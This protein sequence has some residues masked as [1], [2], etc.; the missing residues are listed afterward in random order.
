MNAPYLEPAT[1]NRVALVT[2]AGSGSGRAIAIALAEDGCDV[3]IL[4]RR[5]E[6]LEETATAIRARGRR[7]CIL[8]T[9][10]CDEAAVAAAMEVFLAWSGGRA[11]VLVNA[12]G[13]PGPLLGETIGELK[14]KDF[15]AVMATN[16][17]GP[18]LLMSHLLPVMCRQGNGRVINIG[19]NHGMR[20]RAGRASYASS[21]WA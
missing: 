16:L 17:R 14:V 7:A 6:A 21:K 8:S 5:T 12:A 11:D 18:F 3:A 4:G 13:I 2:G 10:V 1:A 20:G 15:D 19:G 9:D